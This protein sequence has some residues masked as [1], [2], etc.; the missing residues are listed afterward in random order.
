M[1]DPKIEVKDDV[2]TIT[3]NLKGEKQ[4]S[5]TGKMML[6]CSTGGWREVPGGSKARLNLMVGFKSGDL[7][8][9]K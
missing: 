3:V 9:V 1:Q 5:S 8:S 6:V 4:A 2:M 7:A